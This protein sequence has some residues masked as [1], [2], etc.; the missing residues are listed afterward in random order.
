VRHRAAAAVLAV[1]ALALT[2]FLSGCTT[3]TPGTATVTKPPLATAAPANGSTL[4]PAPAPSGTPVDP[5]GYATAAHDGVAFTTTDANTVC[6]ISEPASASDQASATCSIG[7]KDFVFPAL[8]TGTPT[9]VTVSGSAKG[10]TTVTEVT[11]AANS[12]T[13]LA[14][15]HSITFS[16]VT[17]LAI[18]N[19][20]RCT[21]AATSHGFFVSRIEYELF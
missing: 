4:Q 7:Q 1:T 9:S 17:C 20:I 12:T 5:A 11:A 8:A 13:A 6:S 2:A 10:A 14:A 3:A 15:G 21:D 16:T 18:Q 19:G